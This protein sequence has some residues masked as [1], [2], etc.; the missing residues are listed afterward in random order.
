MTMTTNQKYFL[1]AAAV[2]AAMLAGTLV[3]Y[4]QLP[5]MVPIHWNAHGQV[6]GWGPKWSLFFW[7]PGIMTGIVL[8]FAALPWL[9]PK[10]FEVDSFRATYLYIMIVVVALFAYIQLLELA[11]GLGI[12]LDVSRAVEGGVCLLIALLGNVLGKVRRNFYVGVRTP[13]TIAD[14]RV[15]NATHRL[16]AKTFF[17]GGVAGLLAVI[18]RAPFWLPISLVVVA[19]LV[20]VFYSLFFYK[21]LEHRGELR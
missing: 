14:E 1:G 5:S 6:N 12:A 17:A 9:S 8:L 16:A 18:L 21:Q 2:I 19:A 10:K 20:P 4:P 13:W 11:A 7:G 15:W 3:A